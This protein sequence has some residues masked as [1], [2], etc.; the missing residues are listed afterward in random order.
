[1]GGGGGD[2]LTTALPI[3]GTIAGG[4]FGGPAGAAIG[5]GL[6]TSLAGG[7]AG[8]QEQAQ[9]QGAQQDFLRGIV[10]GRRESPLGRRLQGLVGGG[11][12][13]QE[14]A[15]S[16][17]GQRRRGA[18]AAGGAQRR[19]LESALGR[20]G[21]SGGLRAAVQAGQQ[22]GQIQRL[23]DIEA[24]GVGLEQQFRGQ[25]AGQIGNALQ[26]LFPSP[27]A[28]VPGLAQSL[29][30]TSGFGES[31]AGLGST[32][33]LAGLGSALGLFGQGGQGGQAG[34]QTF[35]G[36]LSLPQGEGVDVDISGNPIFGDF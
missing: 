34:A 14:L 5:G 25:Q 1:M 8:G 18:V 26:L 33:G 30:Q 11:P 16:I 13:P 21:A 6:G 17:V 32:V 19:A 10:G 27:G 24:S 12:S 9:A 22:G 36:G 4:A 23:A 28:A 35:G 31:L 29:G 15:Q 2:F 20:A 3:A 7:I